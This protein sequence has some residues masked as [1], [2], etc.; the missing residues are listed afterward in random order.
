M[1]VAAIKSPWSSVSPGRCRGG[2]V[3]ADTRPQDTL[4]VGVGVGSALKGP[5]EHP[6]TP[7]QPRRPAPLRTRTGA[8]QVPAQPCPWPRTAPLL[9]RGQP[10][11]GWGR[12]QRPVHACRP[13]VR[14]ASEFGEQEGGPMFCISGAWSE[15]GLVPWGRPQTAHT[16][17]G[18]GEAVQAH[19]STASSFWPLPSHPQLRQ[20]PHQVGANSHPKLGAS[21][22][23]RPPG[24]CLRVLW[25]CGPAPTPL[26]SGK[27]GPQDVN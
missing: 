16:C 24:P 12:G 27:P 6:A 18:L 21:R 1:E 19:T 3:V 20:L 7:A 26:G 2:G 25:V 10:S 8:R 13:G 22:P 15:A 17:V 9:A 4:P 23:V 5:A 14:D 11:L